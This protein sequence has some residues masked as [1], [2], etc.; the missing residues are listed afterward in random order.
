MSSSR[1]LLVRRSSNTLLG[2][3]A[4]RRRKMGEDAEKDLTDPLQAGDADRCLEN[5][6][7]RAKDD[8]IDFFLQIAVTIRIREG[9]ANHAHTRVT[10]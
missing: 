9:S 7:H 10:Y 1:T 4:L 2:P 5:Q 6:R 3:G 8:A